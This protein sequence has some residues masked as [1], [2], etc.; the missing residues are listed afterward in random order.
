MDSVSSLSLNVTKSHRNGREG[1]C[2]LT[3][4]KVVCTE[5]RSVC[6]MVFC[7]LRG[8]I[9]VCDLRGEKGF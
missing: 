7:F 1:K 8:M 6:G 5:Q 2:W 9:E 3:A 4:Q